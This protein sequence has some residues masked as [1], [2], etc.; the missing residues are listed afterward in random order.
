MVVYELM[1]RDIPVAMF[2]YGE[3]G[4]MQVALNETNLTH[5]PLSVYDTK[6]LLRWLKNR[7]I[8]LTRYDIKNII[9]DPIT[10]MLAHR[11]LSLTDNYW[12]RS[13]G[14]FL[15]WNDVNLYNTTFK[16][17]PVLDVIGELKPTD[18]NEFTPNFS[19]NG[20]L[21]KKWLCNNEG[22]ILLK[23]PTGNNALQSVSE[24]IASK[25]YKNLRICDFVDYDFMVI[26]SA[27]KE[28]LGCQCRNFTN[29][30]LEFVPA[31]DILHGCRQSNNESVFDTFIRECEEHGL[32]NVKKF[33]SAMLSVDFLIANLDRHLNNLGILR[34]P[35]S[36]EWKS[37]APVFDSGNSLFFKS[38]TNAILP[39]GK[40]LLETK[41][42]SFYKT[43][44]KQMSVVDFSIIDLDKTPTLQELEIILRQDDALTDIDIEQRLILMGELQGYYEEMQNGRKLWSYTEL[45]KIKLNSMKIF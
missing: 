26:V 17:S 38:S 16:S 28:A 44:I 8:P 1:H 6:T 19:L 34:D 13:S 3:T 11:G 15:C 42:N 10:T 20:D 30:N 9:E 31:I 41:I 37:M 45:R 24:V 39:K 7:S 14:D 23:G 18:V 21:Q 36:L 43:L 4:A 12:I 25:F 5:L 35:I 32:C 29:E 27:N 2:T 40:D 33:M 22:G